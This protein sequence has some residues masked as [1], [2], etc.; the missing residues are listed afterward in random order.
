MLFEKNRLGIKAVIFDLILFSQ[1]TN[2]KKIELILN[3]RGRQDTL[4]IDD[5]VTVLCFIMGV[6][7]K[8]FIRKRLEN[9]LTQRKIHLK[10]RYDKYFILQIMTE[11]YSLFVW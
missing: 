2:L 4:N 1:I 11:E 3:N 10:G 5:W 7:Q 6:D 8:E 9:V